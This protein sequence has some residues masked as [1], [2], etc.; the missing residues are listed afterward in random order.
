ML[1]ALA[2]VLALIFAPII[3][4]LG[5]FGKFLLKGL[6]KN[7][8]QIEEFKK[9]RKT[10]SIILFC[11]FAVGIALAVLTFTLFSDFA[12][13]GL[14]PLVIG[15]VV[16]FALSIV[17]GNKIYKKHRDEIPAVS[18]DSVEAATDDGLVETEDT[19]TDESADNAAEYI[20][21]EVDACDYGDK[22]KM[23]ALLTELA[24]LRDANV[25]T[26]EEFN[27]QKQQILRAQYK[28]APLQNASNRSSIKEPAPA[29]AKSAVSGGKAEETKEK[30]QRPAKALRVVGLILTILT[31]LT[32]IVGA[33]FVFS[34]KIR[35]PIYLE[36]STCE[37]R[38]LPFHITAFSSSL[39]G[40]SRATRCLLSIIGIILLAVSITVKFAIDIK[41]GKHS[42]FTNRAITMDVISILV[43]A[44]A[45]V[46]SFLTVGFANGAFLVGAI[47]IASCALFI[48]IHLLLSIAGKLSLGKSE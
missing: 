19:A 3:V 32:F 35:Y 26:E 38:Q 12:E 27:E 8:L 10:Y 2:F 43:A 28:S 6:Y 47:L 36:D 7:V 46:F 16:L 24:A 25:L 22:K 13:Y 23:F 15:N 37:Y 29:I 21:D 40:S 39:V 11:W 18:E 17:Y 34:G 44:F 14:Y 5:M 20:P 31:V 1:L 33:V 48:L 42:K 41:C 9:F 30:K 4:V 45:I